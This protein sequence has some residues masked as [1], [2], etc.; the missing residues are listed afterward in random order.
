[1]GAVQTSGE[2][3]RA[4]EVM[5]AAVSKAATVVSTHRRESAAAV[6]GFVV[7]VAVARLLRRRRCVRCAA[8]VPAPAASGV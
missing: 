7:G 3:R 4:A 6:A 2:V 8:P 1:M 5:A